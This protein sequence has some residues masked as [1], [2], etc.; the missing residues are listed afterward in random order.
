MPPTDG[1]AGRNR[2][3][4]RPALH[5]LQ[6][7]SETVLCRPTPTGM[8]KDCLTLGRTLRFAEEEMDF[9]INFDIKYRMGRER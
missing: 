1:G 8:P 6:P 7:A 9:I 5:Y 2:Q 4:G 3:T